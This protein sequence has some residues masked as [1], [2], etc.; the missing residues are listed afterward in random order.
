MGR[1]GGAELRAYGAR[2]TAAVLAA[3]RQ[4]LSVGCCARRG[5]GC[6]DAYE[7]RVA[8]RLLTSSGLCWAQR[9]G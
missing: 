4:R 9:G 2:M 3:A 8:G 5:P 7:A 6:C 1:G